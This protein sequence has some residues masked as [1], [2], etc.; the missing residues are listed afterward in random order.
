MQLHFFN[1]RLLLTIGTVS[2]GLFY[3]SAS[4]LKK[5]KLHYWHLVEACF[6]GDYGWPPS[7]LGPARS[8]PNILSK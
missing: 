7:T 4:F 3:L 6:G 2:G 1:M 8:S 5:T